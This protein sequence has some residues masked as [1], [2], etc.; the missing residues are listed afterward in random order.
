MQNWI[1]SNS[2]IQFQQLTVVF[3]SVIDIQ[4]SC[5]IMDHCGDSF[6]FFFFLES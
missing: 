2:L 1:L 5:S 3:D 4:M 6:T